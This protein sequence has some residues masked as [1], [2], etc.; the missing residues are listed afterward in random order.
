MT[1]MQTLLQ[2]GAVS[3][4]DDGRV[5]SRTPTFLAGNSAAGLLAVDGVVHQ[6]AGFLQVVHRNV[7]SVTGTGGTRFERACSVSVAVELEPIFDQLV[8]ARGQE[9]I[10]SIDEWLE[11]NAR[12]VS[13]SG[14]YAE[15]GAGAYFINFGSSPARSIV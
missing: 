2:F 8:R 13:P 3:M 12:Y 6:L 11:R 9:F 14:C 5:V 1:I 7:C 4:D 15:M 10:D